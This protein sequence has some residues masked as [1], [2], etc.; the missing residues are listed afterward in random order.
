MDPLIKSQL[1][2]QLSYTPIAKGDRSERRAVAGEEARV[3][4][5]GASVY[6]SAWIS[7][8]P[9]GGLPSLGGLQ[10]RP[11]SRDANRFGRLSP[12]DSAVR[13]PRDVIEIVPVSGH[14]S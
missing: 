11:I 9:P 7:G 1:L 2:Y 13:A 5:G 8:P 10:P 12:R 6:P 3:T 14:P 4:N